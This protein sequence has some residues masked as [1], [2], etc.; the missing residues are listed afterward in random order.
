MPSLAPPIPGLEKGGFGYE[1]LRRAFSTPPE[2]DFMGRTRS[3][4]AAVLANVAGLRARG[5]TTAE[6]AN[7]KAK[8]YEDMLDSL[9][10]QGL[11]NATKY[12]MN[13]EGGN[14]RVG[15]WKQRA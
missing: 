6:L 15:R 10:R 1:A 13:P 2:T 7:F 5:V 3:P 4:A 14:R 9:D 11:Q 12:R 8:Q